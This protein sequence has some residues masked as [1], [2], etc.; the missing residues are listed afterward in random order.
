MEGRIQECKGT[1]KIPMMMSNEDLLK[2]F[3]A[4]NAFDAGGNR[5]SAKND[6]GAQEANFSFSPRSQI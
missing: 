5:R 1:E 6:K 4:F 3:E 2:L